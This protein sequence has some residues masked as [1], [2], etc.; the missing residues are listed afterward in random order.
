MFCSIYLVLRQNLKWPRKKGDVK[1]GVCVCF[2]YRAA[3]KRE[4]VGDH[5]EPGVKHEEAGWQKPWA[6]AAHH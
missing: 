1:K 2:F 5:E 6:H 4:R 3:D